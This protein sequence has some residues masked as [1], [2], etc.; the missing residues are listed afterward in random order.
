MI[1]LKFAS[2]KFEDR[3]QELISERKDAYLDIEGKA[4]Y[5]ILKNVAHKYDFDYPEDKLLKL[6]AAVK[7]VVDDKAKY[8]DC[9][10]RDEIKAKLKVDLVILLAEHGYPPISHDEAYKEIFETSR[11]L[12][13]EPCSLANDIKNVT[14]FNI[15]SV[16]E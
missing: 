1:F 8:T 2:D 5:D 7:K 16:N 10:V 15:F 6:A 3:R 9:N 14:G 4:F 11:E 12:Q 13:K